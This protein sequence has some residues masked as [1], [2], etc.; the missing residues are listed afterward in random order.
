MQQG[1]RLAARMAWIECRLYQIETFL[2]SLS[3][4]VMLL[5]IF[6]S[7]CV[8]YFNLPLPNV[9]EWALVAMSPLTFVGAA[10]CSKLGQHIAVDFVHQSRSVTLRK[11]AHLLV[12][13]LLL[14]FSSV[15]T[16]LAWMLLD[17]ALSS[18]ETM[19]DLGTPIAIPVFCY[20]LGML[21]MSIHALCQL[22][23]AAT[24]SALPELATAGVE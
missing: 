11:C 10:M 6:L 16:W 2:C 1:S 17:D 15:Y 7:V 21:L 19:I 14:L 3:L 22:T 5:M 12:S 9:S 13:L 23:R 20:F 4:M 8:R 18:G 24:F